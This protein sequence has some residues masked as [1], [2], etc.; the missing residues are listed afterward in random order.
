[1]CVLNSIFYPKKP[2]KIEKKTVCL[3][4]RRLEKAI[5][6]FQLCYI[7]WLFVCLRESA[8]PPT[9]ICIHAREGRQQAGVEAKTDYCNHHQFFNGRI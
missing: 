2:K 7:F 1:M 9:P 6:V 5:R 3:A 8:I 4:S